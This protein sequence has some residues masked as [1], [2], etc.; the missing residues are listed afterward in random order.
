MRQ[1]R[2]QVVTE[3]SEVNKQNTRMPLPL[4]KALSKGHREIFCIGISGATRHSPE[5]RATVSP[6]CFQK[7]L[8]CPGTVFKAYF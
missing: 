6:H 4:S 1:D 7:H 8:S 5:D 2:K 3:S